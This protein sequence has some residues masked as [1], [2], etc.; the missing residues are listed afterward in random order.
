MKKLISLLTLLCLIGTLPLL[1]GCGKPAE[2]GAEQAAEPAKPLGPAESMQALM[3]GV[4]NQNM[5]AV[6]NFFPASYQQDING[7]VQEFATKMD[8]EMYNG[9]FETGQRLTRLLKDKKEF[10]LKNEMI[11]GLPVPQ[12]KLDQ[13]WEPGVGILSALFNSDVSSLDKLKSF[14]GGKFLSTSGNEIAQNVVTF[15]DL[16]P[17]K[18]GELSFSEKLEQAKVTLVSEEGDTATIKLEVPGEKPEEEVLVK[19]EE[20]WIPKTLADKWKSKMEDAHQKLAELTPEKVTAQKGQ[21]LSGLKTMNDKLAKLE[22][23]KNEE[24]FNKQ[25]SQ[26]LAPLAMLG[27]MLMMQM[28]QSMQAGPGPAMNPSL[29]DDQPV[30]PEKVVTIIVNRKPSD[31]ELEQILGDL[32]A[33]MKGTNNL[34]VSPSKDGAQTIITVSPIDNVEDFAKKLKFGKVTNVD[35]QKRSI[36]LELAK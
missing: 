21:Y 20:K 3:D 16:I 11:K 7:L 30:S 23:A 15:S 25:L 24:E 34:N 6:W 2:P 4:A 5:E 26:E 19:V 28:G 1:P 22:S 13:Y 14:D 27:P 33:L 17:A 9:S 29:G 31:S 32:E 8:P 36:T 18:E 10:I 12:D 35:S